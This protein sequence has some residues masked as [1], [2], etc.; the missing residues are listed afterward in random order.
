MSLNRE[1]WIIRFRLLVSL[2]VG[3][4]M[5]SKVFFL[6]VFVGESWPFRIRFWKKDDTRQLLCQIFDAQYLSVWSRLKNI[7]ILKHIKYNSS[8]KYSISRNNLWTKCWQSI[9]SLLK[10]KRKDCNLIWSQNEVDVFWCAKGLF[11][12]RVVTTRIGLYALMQHCIPPNL[13]SSVLASVPLRLSS[14]VPSLLWVVSSHTPEP[15]PL[16][17]VVFQ[18]QVSLTLA[19]DI[20]MNYAS[21]WHGD[22]LWCH[23]VTD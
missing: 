1:L 10:F 6:L 3:S 15:E 11:K 20:S 18:L 23:K 13:K 14:R 5:F 8:Q 17:S 4:F 2:S 21:V 22:I 12:L 7:L 9:T 16:S 19:V